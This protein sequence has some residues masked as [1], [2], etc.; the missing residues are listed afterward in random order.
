VGHQDSRQE[1]H[2]LAPP[3]SSPSS[4]DAAAAG[5]PPPHPPPLSKNHPK[6]DAPRPSSCNLGQ[7]EAEA[8]AHPQ[9]QG[10]ACHPYAWEH[11][12]HPPPPIQPLPFEPSYARDEALPALS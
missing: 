1:A 9:Q 3:P 12:L 5:H 6:P 4:S 7:P 10:V 8:Q 2:G 11:E